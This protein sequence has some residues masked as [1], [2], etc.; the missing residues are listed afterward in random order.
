MRAVELFCLTFWCLCALSWARQPCQSPHM[1]HGTLSV[2]SF[3]GETAAFGDF[4]YDSQGKKLRFVENEEYTNKTSHDD[5][6][7]LMLFEEGVFY[8][9]DSKNQSCKKM[10]LHSRKHPMELP[11]DANHLAEM[12]LGSDSVSDQGVRLRIWLGKFPELNANYSI[13]TTS[14]GCLTLSTAYNGEKKHLLFSFLNVE[15]EVKD[16]HV[17]VPPSYCDGVALED[18]GDEKNSFFSL[19]E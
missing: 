16:P 8:E 19:F 15:T 3:G 13:T 5:M 7:V 12:Y 1:T 6:D 18:S 10:V 11:P 2:T 17:F 4:S 14:C 9:I